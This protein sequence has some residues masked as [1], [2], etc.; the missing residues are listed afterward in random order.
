M[1]SILL[2]LCGLGS[3]VC[4]IMVLIPLFKE[5]GALHGIL[6]I[7]CSLYAFIWGWMNAGRLGIKNMMIIWS[8]LILVSIVLNVMVTS[9]AVSQMQVQP[10]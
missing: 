10:Q 1:L 3:L 5:K 6:G 7:L 2:V 9:A 8:I 4:W